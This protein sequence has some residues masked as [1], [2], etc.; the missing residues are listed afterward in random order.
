MTTVIASFNVA[1]WDHWRAGY[2]NAVAGDP[3]LRSHRIWRGQDDP[4]HVVI[5]ETFD[6][7]EIAERVFTSDETREAMEADGIDM[8]T[9]HYEFLAEAD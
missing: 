9:L 4:N 6:T 8:S 5:A 2:A 1:D 3:D 7:R